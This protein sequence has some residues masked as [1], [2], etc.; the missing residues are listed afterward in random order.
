MENKTKSVGELIDELYSLR[1]TRLE[2]AKKVKTMAAQEGG[3][4][5][6]IIAQ[7]KAVG[8]DGGKGQAANALIVKSTEAR[9][10][11]WPAFWAFCV[12][13]DSPDLVQKRVSITAV[14]ERW[15]SGEEIAGLSKFEAEDISLTKR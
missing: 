12:E 10:D 5:A 7:L 14:R 11:D 8:L 15:E 3:I 4:R 13:S 1:A 9:I 6:N 2:L